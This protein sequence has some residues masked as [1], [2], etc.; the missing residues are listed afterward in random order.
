MRI[1]NQWVASNFLTVLNRNQTELSRLQLQVSSGKQYSKASENPVN[2]A[3]AMYHKTEITEGS[4][5]TKNIDRTKEWLD[6]TDT[7]LTTLETVLQ[8]ARELAV[9][10]ANDTLVQQDRDAIAEEIDQLLQQV[11]DIANTDIGGEYI[12]GGNDVKTKPI[13]LVSGQTPGALRDI[14]TYSLGETRKDMNIA[15]VIDIRYAGDSKRLATEITKGVLVDRNVSALEVFY[16]GTSSSAQPTFGNRLPPLNELTPLAML[17]GGR[18]VQAGVMIVTDSNGIDRKIDLTHVSNLDDVL[19]AINAT[20]SFKA[21]IEEVP[22]DTAAAL[23]I[24]RSAGP[25]NTLYGLSDP[26]MMDRNTPLSALNNGLGVPEGFLNIN[27]RDGRNL[28]VD[29]SGAT[30]VGGVIDAINAADGGVSVKATYDFIGKRLQITDMT[31]GTGN[32]SI[33][34]K[35]TQLYLED[36]PSHSAADL[37]LLRNVGPGGQIVQSYDPAIE[38]EATKL[39]ALNGGKGFETGF[40]DITGHNGTTTRVDLRQAGTVQDVIDAISS[41]TGGAQTAHLDPDSKRLV[42]T[43]TT[44]GT[45]DFKITEVDGS[46]PVAVRDM[47]T[48]AKSLGLLQ[49]SNNGTIVGSVLMPPALT[50]ASSLSSLVPPPEPG[51]MVIRGADG[52]PVQIDLTRASTI[53]DVLDRVNETGKF[54]AVWDG[55]HNRFTI[56]D[57]SGASGDKGIT[58]EEYTNPARDLG[59]LTGSMHYTGNVLTGAP[60]TARSLPTLMGSVD[61]NPAVEESTELASLNSGRTMNKGTN[62]GFIRIT[63]K[64]GNFKAIDLRGAKTIKD[65]LDRINDRTNQLGIEARINSARNGIELIDKTG[66]PG[67]MEVI[68]IDST[69]ASD[70]GIKGRTIDSRLV[71]TDIDPAVNLSTRISS[72]RVNEGGVPLG[73]IYVQ[74]GSYSGKIDLSGATT[75]GDLIEKL[76]FSDTNFKMAAWVDTDGKRLNLT[77]TS[78]EA[79]IKVRDLGTSD[80]GSASALG[81]GGSR[82]IFETLQDLRD[83]LYRNDSKAISDENIKTIQEDIE[84][85]LKVHAEVGSRTNRVTAAKEKIESITLNLKNMLS[86]VEDVDMTEAITRMT[87]I[88]TA[89]RAA[90][91]SGAKILQTT[92]MDFLG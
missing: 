7:S 76:T 77:N 63:D 23:G 52:K 81:L 5:Y 60:I 34:S 8:R 22:S 50:P 30:T 46:Q 73:E 16:R 61:L 1:S 56:G 65:V 55:V 29:L 79:Y 85:V 14:V 35:K 88:E 4:Q 33:E 91:Q 58:I 87:T 42:I 67:Q 84:R 44:S 89:F 11:I 19:Y 45:A 78:G 13:S 26:A 36:L 24:Y 54:E 38:N 86:E 72:L 21:G 40:I 3:L 32:F 37:G 2:N 18:G 66:G 47:T 6:N 74:S 41:Q 68:D 75:V 31:T 71:G 59:F 27:T 43:D 9:Q 90:L 12:F 39:S 25:A 20:G 62:L 48:V 53:Q 49:G 17:N 51:F 92:L 80:V 10:G 70:L 69:T 15:N 64:A 28:R 57:I 83:N 82:S